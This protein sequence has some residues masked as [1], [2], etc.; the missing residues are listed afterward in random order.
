MTDTPVND[1]ALRA[2]VRDD[3]LVRKRYRAERRFR[4]YGLAAIMAA[5]GVLTV[6]I[7]SIVSA[8]RP[9]F[10]HDRGRPDSESLDAAET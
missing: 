10:I 9:A 2:K 6:L 4:A 8:G 3:A 1:G 7:F 5:L